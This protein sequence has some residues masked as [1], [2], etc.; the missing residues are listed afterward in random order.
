RH[1]R[2]RPARCPRLER[3]A[4]LSFVGTAIAFWTLAAFPLLVVWSVLGGDGTMGVHAEPEPK[5][6][7]RARRYSRLAHRLRRC[8]VF[9]LRVRGSV[10]HR[11]RGS[12]GLFVGL[13]VGYALAGYSPVF[14]PVLKTLLVTALVSCY[15]TFLVRSVMEVLV[16][17]LGFHKDL[18]TRVEA[19]LAEERTR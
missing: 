9:Q 3:T 4:V 12:T 16:R 14:Q 5:A 2:A 1:V 6:Y 15:P 10:F 19:R 11:C 8:A 7:R 17:R 13:T 18:W